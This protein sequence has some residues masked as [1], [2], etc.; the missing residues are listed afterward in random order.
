[1]TKEISYL[2]ALDEALGKVTSGP[3]ERGTGEL[4]RQLKQY[5]RRLRAQIAL[6]RRI[7]RAEDSYSVGVGMSQNEKNR[8]A[9]NTIV[10]EAGFDTCLRARAPR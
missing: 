4:R 8:D 7:A 6:D 5:R 9:R 2:K 1:M 10:D 3:P